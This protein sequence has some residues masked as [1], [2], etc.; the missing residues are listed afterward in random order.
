MVRQEH[1]VYLE[2][3]VHKVQ[4]VLV[5]VMVQQVH[6]VQQ[7]LVVQQVQVVPLEQ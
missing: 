4:V 5:V 7:E 3:L 1:L 6:Q 2:L